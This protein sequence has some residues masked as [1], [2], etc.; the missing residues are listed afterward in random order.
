MGWVGGNV[1]M[2]DWNTAVCIVLAPD[3]TPQLPYTTN[4]CESQAA[5]G[6]KQRI[7]TQ[8]TQERKPSCVVVTGKN[9]LLSED[10]TSP[11]TSV[12]TVSSLP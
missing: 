5:E 1:C 7:S 6:F 4:M 11:D 2:C 3:S 8:V 12:A 10:L 9:I